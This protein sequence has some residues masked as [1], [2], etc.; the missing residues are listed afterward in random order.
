MRALNKKRSSIL[1]K[2]ALL[3]WA[4]LIV[5]IFL[6]RSRITLDSILSYSP[7]NLW[8][9]ALVMMG[10]FALKT[11]SVVFY[12][13]LLFTAAG[14]IFG[15]PLAIAVDIAGILVMLLEGYAIG[16][17]GGQS[18]VDDLSRKY[19]RFAAFNGI[20]DRS[21]FAFALLLRMLKV[22]N[23]DLG[24]MYMGA[25]GTELVPFLAGSMIALIPEA[26]LFSL[27]GSGLADLNAV[28]A[29]AAGA[30]YVVLS[31]TSVLGLR[32]MMKKGGDPAEE[33]PEEA[34]LN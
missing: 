7:S 10:L 18:L 30:A 19:P 4:A 25:S 20:K 12:S 33:N 22:I 9:A 11:L 31:L 28:P 15:M 34:I 1:Q 14:V 27:A 3:I 29:A 5:F 21:P 32:Y 17:A 23:Y 2:A 16:R 24:S 6:N 8:L 26:V 13:G